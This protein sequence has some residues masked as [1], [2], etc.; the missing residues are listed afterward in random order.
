MSRLQYIN[1]YDPQK[2]YTYDERIRL[3]RELKIAQ[4]AEKARVMSM[5]E[6]DYGLI[7]QDEYHFT[8]RPNHENGSIYGY[9]G[10]RDN[11]IAV[12]DSHPLYVNPL[13][14]FVGKGLLLMER[15]RPA[16]K[17]WNPAY[18]Y[19]ALEV[20]FQ[21]YGIISGI[22]N[23]HH[24]TPALDIGF[25]LGWG[26]ILEK[27]REQKALHD[28][29]HALFYDSEIAVVE[30]IIRFLTRMADELSALA[31]KERNSS[32]AENLRQMS[33]MNRKLA[34]GRPETF[35]EAVQWLCW[36]SMI[37]RTYNRGSAG[38]QLEDL[39]GAFYE[40]DV[41]AGILTDD[42]ARFYLSCMFL[43][44]SRY[45][46]IGGPDAE[47]NDVT[48]RLSYLALEAA[49]AL[50]LAC[51]LTVRVHDRLDPVFLRKAVEC[52][53]RNGQG[54]PR[55]SSDKYLM[56][57]FMRCGYS[58]AL[59]RRRVTAGCHWMCMPGLEY[60]M[61]DTVKINLA[62]VFEVAWREM[63]DAGG[64]MDAE[65]LFAHF[66]AHLKR[67]VDA[68]GEGIMHHLK[69]QHFSQPELILNLF[70]YG[71]IEKGVNVT[72]GGTTYYNMCVDG[73]GIAVAADSFAAC[74][75]R[76]DRE[77]K[78]TYEQLRA[79]TDCDFNAPDGERARLLLQNSPRFGGGDTAGDRW[80]Q[81]INRAF[82]ALVRDLNRQHPGYNFIPGYFSW[83][84][85]VMLGEM[86]GATPNGRHAR[87][88]INHGANPLGGFRRD[89]A[90]SAMC[91]SIAAIQP[92]YGNTA[93]VQLELDPTLAADEEGVETM[94]AMILSI[95]ESGNTLL[96]INLI[97]AEKILEADKNP[98]L[99]PD[100]VVRVTGFTAFFCMLSPEFRALVV[101]RV[102]S[103]NC[104]VLAERAASHPESEK[105]D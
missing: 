21:R 15:L 2:V 101:D 4:T 85:T 94:T 22:D 77:H 97:D 37:S 9:D 80:A 105:G 30:A 44:D 98:F 91:N 86:V 20:E 33:K 6:D 51:N 23:A 67:A 31:E 55:F 66:E 88:P 71:L 12:L 62:K 5:D 17:K 56:E 10:W 59:A 53:L 49:D 83:S 104:R 18:P 47:G 7:E 48:C 60:T 90:L 64:E 69:Y 95:L 52:L 43:Q 19:D 24:F 75:A 45:F 27:L 29:S 36:F 3:L 26:G 16:D 13:D 100:L 34:A 78:L 35:K 70:Q 96:N 89:G 28:E 32:L 57:G 73:S 103:V 54:W 63:T 41:A 8:L 76:V 50:N 68:T 42:E 65:R 81:R 93:P 38:G 99:Y 14:A 82:T 1:Y 72:Q 25:S 79:L 74:E 92:G 102:K 40:A 87:A 11:F 39:L 84:S 61:N 46:Q 58:R